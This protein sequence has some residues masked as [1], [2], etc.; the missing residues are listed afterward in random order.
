MAAYVV[1]R[2]SQAVPLLI[3]I[4]L[5]AFV[6]L[7]LAPGGPMAVYA[8]NP[9]M[10]EADMRRLEHLLGLDQPVHV[11]YLRWAAGMFSGH[12][13]YSYR[14]GRPVGG[15]ILER[16]PATLELMT[17]AYAIAMLLGVATGAVS[18]VRRYS[19]L[20]YLI[21]PAAM[22]GLSLPIFWFGLL[23]IIVGAATLHWI[24]SGGIA[25]RTSPVPRWCSGSG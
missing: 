25:W 11:Q 20:D 16:V 7:R 6:M 22:I 24:P 21:T 9:S 18:A 5:V 3:G 19:L 2:L 1:R 17:A 4:S 14:P 15:V 12:L 13:G 23:V 10:T 8:Q